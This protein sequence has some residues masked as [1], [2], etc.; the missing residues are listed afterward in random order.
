MLKETDTD[1]VSGPDDS[2]ECPRSSYDGH[3]ISLDDNV[4]V[5]QN[6]WMQTDSILRAIDLAQE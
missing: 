2:E 5:I 6:I 4:P 1:S 3:L